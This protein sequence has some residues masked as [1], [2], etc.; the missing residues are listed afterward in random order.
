MARELDTS[1]YFSSSIIKQIADGNGSYGSHSHLHRTNNTDIKKTIPI[2]LQVYFDGVYEYIHQKI[3][4]GFII[5]PRIP[6]KFEEFA[7]NSYMKD[8]GLT[9]KEWD[10]CKHFFEQRGFIIEQNERFM[11][12][13]WI[14]FE[15]MTQ[16]EGRE[17]NINKEMESNIDKGTKN[18][19]FTIF[20]N[21][22][23]FASKGTINTRYENRVKSYQLQKEIKKLKRKIRMMDKDKYNKRYH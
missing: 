17:N 16:D 3:Q 18:K 1:H 8:E 23:C 21:S 13:A 6:S 4:N 10:Y 20:K 11:R 7:W 19:F 12:I 2:S 5:I 22:W 14:E 15:W 9:Y